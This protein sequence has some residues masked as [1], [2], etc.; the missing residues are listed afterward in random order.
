MTHTNLHPPSAWLP[1]LHRLKSHWESLLVHMYMY[2]YMYM[3]M[4]VSLVNDLM[5]WLM[6]G[7]TPDIVEEG[8]GG[9]ALFC[10]CCLTDHTAPTTFILQ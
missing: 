9:L 3:Y 2:M 10:T 8:K 4:C 6:S 5:D 1:L 7:A